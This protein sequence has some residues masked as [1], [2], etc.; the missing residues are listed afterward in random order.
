MWCGGGTASVTSKGGGGFV[1][2]QRSWSFDFSRPSDPSNSP[3]GRV[4]ANKSSNS[5]NGR[6][7]PNKQSNL[8]VR[9]VGSTN[10][11]SSRPRSS[12]LRDRIELALVSSRS[13]SLL[14]LSDLKTA[15]TRFLV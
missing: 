10:L 6:V 15:R 14:E 1:K 12:L 8:P 9:R 4:G 11:S 2:R 13:E 5:P 3:N 7:G